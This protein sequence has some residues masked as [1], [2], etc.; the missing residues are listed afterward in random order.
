MIM[1]KDVESSAIHSASYDTSN[2]TLT[3]EFNRGGKYE[4]PNVPQEHYQGLVDAPSVGKYFHENIKQ[5][6]VKKV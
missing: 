3:I 4:Y 6:S 5:Y 2:R 1:H